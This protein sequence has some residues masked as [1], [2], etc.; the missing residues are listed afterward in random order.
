MQRSCAASGIRSALPFVVIHQPVQEFP[1]LPHRSSVLVLAIRAASLYGALAT[2]AALQAADAPVVPALGAANVFEAD[3]IL[4]TVN[5]RPIPTESL[6][7]VV[8][9]L[10]SGQD[11]V[12]RD[13]ILQELINMEVLAQAAERAELNLTPRIASALML[14]YTQTLAN[15]FLAEQNAA[16]E[17]DEAELRAE[18]ERQVA[19]LPNSDYRAAHILVADRADAESV[20]A[21]LAEGA[22]FGDLAAEHSIDSNAAR[23]GEFGWLTSASLSGPLAQALAG[24]SPGAT[25]TEAVQTEYGFHVLKL[26]ETRSA[27]PPQFDDVR[28]LMAG[29]LTRRA[30]SE[31]T[32]QL[33]EQADV[34]IR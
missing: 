34:V 33:R 5:G 12:D 23:G 4:A 11:D 26:H 1:M 27:T 7:N 31:R 9:Q 21:A 30:L 24:M 16:L 25:S 15:A 19:A 6:E 29:A 32:A 10:E 8:A 20:I 28:E 17:F 2:G 3:D 22:D 14:Q 18:Y 13:A